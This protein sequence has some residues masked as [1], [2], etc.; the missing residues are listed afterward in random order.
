M[1]PLHLLLAANPLKAFVDVTKLHPILVDFTAALV[2]VSV[3][4]DLLARVL[5]NDEF[6]ITAWWSMVIATIITPFTVIAGWL[7]WASDDN[8]DMGMTIHKWLG[9]ALGVLI[10]GLFFWRRKFRAKRIPVDYF[11]LAVAILFVVAL[12]IQGTLGGQK[13]FSG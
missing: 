11:Y 4:T 3:A 2:P 13:V 8:G 9:T 10:I 7:F 1:P 5:K 12:V 6:R